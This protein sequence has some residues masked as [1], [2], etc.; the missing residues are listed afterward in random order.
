MQ[1]RMLA[2]EVTYQQYSQMSSSKP[3]QLFV[4]RSQNLASKVKETF[5]EM[6]NTH[7]SGVSSSSETGQQLLVNADEENRRECKRFG[8]LTNDEFPLFVS[9]DHVSAHPSIGYLELICNCTLLALL[10]DRGRV[11]ICLPKLE[12][13]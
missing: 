5:Y 1:M 3:R 8:M 9:F 11:T 6:Y 13:A 12:A 4:T 10:D 2:A 7:I